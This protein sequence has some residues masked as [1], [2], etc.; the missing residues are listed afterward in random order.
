MVTA[1]VRRAEI[2]DPEITGARFNKEQQEADKAVR[3][4]QHDLFPGLFFNVHNP[5]NRMV[6]AEDGVLRCIRCNW[7][8]YSFDVRD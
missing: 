7:E 4:T 3:D 8:V 6:D 2:V 5:P 1:F